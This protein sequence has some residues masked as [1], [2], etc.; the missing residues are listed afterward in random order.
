[1]RDLH[2]SDDLF[3]VVEKPCKLHASP[4]M[5]EKQINCFDNS[6][7]YDLHVEIKSKSLGTELNRTDDHLIRKDFS[8]EKSPW[9][10]DAEKSNSVN[11]NSQDIDEVS[12]QCKQASGCLNSVS[13]LTGENLDLSNSYGDRDVRSVGSRND[14]GKSVF[15][16][17]EK[18]SKASSTTQIASHAAMRK[19][20]SSS[21]ELLEEVKNSD[22]RISI[23]GSSSSGM[24]RNCIVFILGKHS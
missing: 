13:A 8:L 16:I 19:Q 22:K 18:L 21:N 10:L 4:S 6:D 5:K 12:A 1:M 7:G 23:V 20:N 14:A 15:E 2:S 24:V 3:V 17:D 9:C 11:E